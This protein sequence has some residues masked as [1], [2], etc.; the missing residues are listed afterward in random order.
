MTGAFRAYRFFSDWGDKRQARQEASAPKLQD[1]LSF[2]ESG[3]IDPDAV[4]E[5]M[6]VE[7]KDPAIGT[8]ETTSLSLVKPVYN[9]DAQGNTEAVPFPG[10]MA[11]AADEQK[12]TVLDKYSSNPTM[13]AFTKELQAALGPRADFKELL[14]PNFDKK[15]SNNPQVQKI[16]LKYTKDPAFMQLMKEMMK[17]KEFMSAFQEQVLT[18]KGK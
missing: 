11:A 13:E 15:N 17:D 1:S 8:P 18:G 14:N 16:L 3:Y 5:K 2:F 12:P 10:Q 7:L 6:G 9:P 4:Q